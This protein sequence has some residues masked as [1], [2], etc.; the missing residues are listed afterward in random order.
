MKQYSKHLFDM[1]QKLVSLKT[2]SSKDPLIDCSN[3]KCIELL[4]DWLSARDFSITIIQSE[5]LPDKINLIASKGEGTP[6]RSK[7]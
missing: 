1:T 4:A 3:K 5:G 7:G 2:V 6:G